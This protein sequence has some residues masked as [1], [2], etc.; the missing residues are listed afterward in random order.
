MCCFCIPAPGLQ[1][2]PEEEIEIVTNGY[3]ELIGTGGFASVYKGTQKHAV[4]AVKVLNPV[5]EISS[6]LFC[7]WMYNLIAELLTETTQK[8][9]TTELQALTR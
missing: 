9:F 3:R 8:T 2:F 5:S 4:V 1:E 6:M 7:A